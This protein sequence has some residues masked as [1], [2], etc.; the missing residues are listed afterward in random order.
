LLLQPGEVALEELFSGLEEL[1]YATFVFCVLWE[2][3][4]VFELLVDV[5]GKVVGCLLLLLEG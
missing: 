2:L 4:L 1:F 5:E 3:V